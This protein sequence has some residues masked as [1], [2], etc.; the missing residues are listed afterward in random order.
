M[1]PQLPI[2][3]CNNNLSAT[4][5]AEYAFNANQLLPAPLRIHNIDFELYSLQ[6][7]LL[8]E[9]NRRRY[10]H[11]H[12]LQQ[13]KQQVSEKENHNQPRNASF[14]EKEASCSHHPIFVNRGVCHRH[15]Y[16]T[17]T[18][19]CVHPECTNKARGKEGVCIRHGAKKKRKCTHD[20]CTSNAVLAGGVCKKHGNKKYVYTCKLEGCKSQ[21]KRGGLCGR[22]IRI[23]EKEAQM[24]KSSIEEIV[25]CTNEG[26]MNNQVKNGLCI[27][28]GFKLKTSKK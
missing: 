22:H 6:Q 2:N 21:A 19:T 26:W 15:G 20:G 24:E 4:S 8:E 17:Y 25:P 23:R 5:M 16:K 12:Q 11:L 10:H 28:H 7:T 9:E 3:D 13:Q 1:P 14:D 27:M 18:Y